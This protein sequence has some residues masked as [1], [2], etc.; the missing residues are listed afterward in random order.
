MDKLSHMRSGSPLETHRIVLLMGSMGEG[1]MSTHH[2]P[3]EQEQ[4]EAGSSQRDPLPQLA[5]ATPGAMAC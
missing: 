2:W 1:M 4:L 5:I 3:Q